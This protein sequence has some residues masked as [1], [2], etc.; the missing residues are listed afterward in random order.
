MRFDDFSNEQ[1]RSQTVSGLVVSDKS[2]SKGPADEVR[3]KLAAYGLTL[4]DVY[5]AALIEKIDDVERF[6]KMIE[7]M[8]NRRKKLFGEFHAHRSLN[9]ETA[10]QKT[11]TIVDQFGSEA[12]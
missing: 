1:F 7:T 2:R 4:E 10:K 6:D 8:E 12:A 5:D 9:P 3:R 11:I